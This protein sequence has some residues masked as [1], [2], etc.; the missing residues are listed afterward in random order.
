MH[1]SMSSGILTEAYKFFHLENKKTKKR[2][3]LIKL[4]EKT[5]EYAQCF[6]IKI[7]V[8]FLNA[9]PVKNKICCIR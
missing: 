4:H 7:I 1:N 5:L 3:M 8:R 2:S 6:S 9:L